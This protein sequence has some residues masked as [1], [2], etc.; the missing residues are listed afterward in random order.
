VQLKLKLPYY[1]EIHDR[2]TAAWGRFSETLQAHS[3]TDALDLLIEILVANKP[4]DG[5]AQP[6]TAT[7]VLLEAFHVRYS[8]SPAA[9][10]APL[11]ATKVVGDQSFKQCSALVSLMRSLLTVLRIVPGYAYC[12]SLTTNTASVLDI[13]YAISVCRAETT[14]SLPSFGTERMYAATSTT[15]TDGA[16]LLLTPPSPPT[17]VVGSTR[18]DLMPVASEL[19]TIVLDIQYRDACDI[20]VCVAHAVVGLIVTDFC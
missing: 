18:I 7:K 8:L 16:T 4:C 11:L 17:C 10:P 5:A 6:T 14:Q 9:S 2:F 12:R 3:Q 19:G 13:D 15:A 1:Q 20:S